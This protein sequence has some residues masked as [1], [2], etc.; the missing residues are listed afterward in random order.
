VKSHDHAGHTHDVNVKKVDKISSTKVRLTVEFSGDTLRKHEESMTRRYSAQ[1]RIPGF[2]PGKAPVKMIK[3]KYKDEIR[4]EVVSHL[5]EA[6]L[7]EALEQTK[8]M[9]ISR[10]KIQLKE[11]SFDDGK[12]F[13]FE[14]EFDVPP[15]IELKSY[16]GAPLKPA[17]TDVTDEEVKNTL[18]GLRE[19]MAVLEPLDVK[20]P[21][22]G[23]YAVVEI[24]YETTG[25]PL[26]KEEPKQYTVQLGEDQILM[27]E[28]DAAMMSLTV[29]ESKTVTSK[30]PDEYT[31][32]AL[33]GREA[34]F[35]CKLL[36][37]KKKTMPELDDAFAAQLREGTTL[38]SLT[39]EI[40]QNIEGAKK[41]DSDKAK[42]EEILQ[43]LVA[44]NPF[45]VPASMVEQQ[46]G[47][48][49]QWMQDDQKRR[50]Q[51]PV[52][53]NT[54]NMESLKKR[55]E[56]MVRGS[57]LLKE[58]AVKEKISL[59]EKI[60]EARIQDIATQLNRD[61]DDTKK[62]LSGKG[63]MDRLRDEVLTDQVYDFLIKN[64]QVSESPRS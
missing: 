27:P 14:A 58:V 53:M 12:P 43:Y 17:E 11:L 56:Q 37:L 46:M 30:F 52:Q 31:D 35:S 9:P 34:T 64:S 21:E 24:G 51:A 36:E 33:A 41:E 54:E 63:M 22:K 26:K 39:K 23:N 7:G 32:P 47:M 50:G 2:R 4:K 20:T 38:E 45:E 3:E 28:L 49:L 15:E 42:R 13:E 10:P 19:R 61:L 62:W 60:V 1:A 16:K 57:L 29:G 25:E 40:R 44:Q 55:A 5:L 8:L 59:D 18:N 48:L 6:G